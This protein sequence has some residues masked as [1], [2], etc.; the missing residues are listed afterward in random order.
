MMPGYEIRRD[1]LDLIPFPIEVYPALEA[2]APAA[3][4]R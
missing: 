3:I 2:A 1:V 4:Q